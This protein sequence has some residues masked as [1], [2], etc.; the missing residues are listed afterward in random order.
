M[1]RITLNL[2]EKYQFSTE[3]QVRICDINYGGHLSNDAT[4]R[5]IQEARV[6]FFDALGYDHENVDVSIILTD[7]VIL[8]KAE[9]FYRDRLKIEVAATD[10]TKKSFDLMY[11]VT[12]IKNGKEIARAKTGILAFDYKTRKV[13]TLHE[14]IIYRFKNWPNV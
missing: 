4:L 7:S 11:R 14:D 3:I 1:A 9:G 6:R 5:L 13:S 12:N 2:P 8:Y 10:F